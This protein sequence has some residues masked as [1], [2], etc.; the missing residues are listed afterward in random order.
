[1]A[2][3]TL[4]DAQSIYG[5]DA[6]AVVCDRDQDGTVD[7]TSFALHLTIASEQ[8]DGYLLGRYSLPL[9]TPPT[10]FKKYAVDLAIYNCALGADVRTEEMRLRRDDAISYLDGVASG[11]IKL[12]VADSTTTENKAITPQYTTRQTELVDCGA[13]SMRWRGVL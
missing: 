13:R 9:A 1:V 12:I 7:S 2:Y 5:A 4:A 6:I 11:R 8:I 10:I 3:A